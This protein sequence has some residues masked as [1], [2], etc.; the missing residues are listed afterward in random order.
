M[1]QFAGISLFHMLEANG[2]ALTAVA[3][4]GSVG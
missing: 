3:C 2:L 1:K 4:Y